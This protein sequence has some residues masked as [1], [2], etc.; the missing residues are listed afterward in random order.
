ISMF[1][2]QKAKEKLADCNVLLKYMTFLQNNG[3][4]DYGKGQI[5]GQVALLKEYLEDGVE[6][7]ERDK[8]ESKDSILTDNNKMYKDKKVV[9]QQIVITKDNTLYE[10]AGE[11]IAETIFRKGISNPQNNNNNN[12]NNKS[13][14]L[15][16]VENI[17]DKAR[18]IRILE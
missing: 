13:G 18:D 8:E 11:K 1:S 15:K 6:Q 3:F 10:Q 17:I 2:I 14:L 5:M 4:S 16:G 9:E 7:K 12:N